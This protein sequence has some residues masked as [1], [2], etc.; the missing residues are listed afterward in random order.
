MRTA[1]VQDFLEASCSL[2]A[3]EKPAAL[4]FRVWKRGFNLSPRDQAT[5]VRLR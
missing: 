4:G 5:R 2:E 1:T 3:P